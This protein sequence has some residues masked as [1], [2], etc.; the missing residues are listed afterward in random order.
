M[1]NVIRIATYLT[2]REE[3]PKW[4]NLVELSRAIP[5]PSH[6]AEIAF[7]ALKISGGNLVVEGI[8]E[9]LA[10]DDGNFE[11]SSG[12]VVGCGLYG[13][14]LPFTRLTSNNRIQPEADP[15]P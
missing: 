5:V 2:G 6:P 12:A 14:V 13:P 8:H 15:R 10:G 1:G 11:V 7:R 4:I 3:K 9:V